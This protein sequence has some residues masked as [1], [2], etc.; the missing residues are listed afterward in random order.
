MNWIM[1]Y[2]FKEQILKFFFIDTY[3]CG[4]Q[5]TLIE[6]MLILESNHIQKVLGHFFFTTSCIFAKR[7]S[8]LITKTALL[9][10][11]NTE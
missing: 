6:T 9:V 2:I 3:K 1:Y 7:S 8:T 4:M 10:S 11:W 5:E